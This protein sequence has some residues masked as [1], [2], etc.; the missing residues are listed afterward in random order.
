MS[1][2]YLSILFVFLSMLISTERDNPEFSVRT[3]NEFNEMFTRTEG[4]TGGDV[5]HTIA[6]SDSVVLWV[7]GD[8]WIGP[9]INGK[10]YD[11]AMIA[12][13]I[14]V[15]KGARPDPKNI[16]FYNKTKKRGR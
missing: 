16:S 7:F 12:N 1:L 10:H 11:A 2:K 15:Q 14:A 13:S 8:T 3:D 9:V 6:L 5:A 4:W